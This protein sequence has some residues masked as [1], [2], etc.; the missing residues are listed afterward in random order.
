MA[1]T[2][3]KECGHEVASNAKTCP[4]CGVKYPGFA[5]GWI[6]LIIFFVLI[7]IIIGAIDDSNKNTSSKGLAKQRE[8]KWAHTTVNVRSGRSTDF[9]IVTKLMPDEKVGVDSLFNGWYR[10]FRDGKKI[11]YVASFLLKDD[12]LWLRAG[13]N[14]WSGV[15]LYHGSS[16]YKKFAGEV[17]GGRDRSLLI[18]TKSGDIECWNRNTMIMMD[19]YIRSDDPALKRKK[20]EIY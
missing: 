10:V 5:L 1:L 17:L 20:W 18:K 19:Y 2:K 16:S 9:S 15:K 14:I 12:Q 8:S 6:G 4:N 11:G 7:L 3:C 13:G